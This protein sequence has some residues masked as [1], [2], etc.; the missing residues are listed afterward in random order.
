MDFE[1]VAAWHRQQYPLMQGQDW[2]K[3]CYQSEFGAGHMIADSDACLK[4]LQEEYDHTPAL[5][6]PLFEEIGSGLCRLHL[7]PLH[8]E[9]VELKWVA[10]LFQMAAQPR[11]TLTGLEAKLAQVETPAFSDYFRSYRG[12]GC[13]AVSHSEVY[14]QAYQPAYRLVPEWAKCRWPLIKA[15]DDLLQTEERVVIAI[16]GMSGSGKSTLGAHLQALFGGNLLHMD[17]FFLPFEKKTPHR[18]CQ[19]GGNVDHERFKAEVLAPLQRGEPFTFRPYQ[20]HQGRLGQPIQVTPQPLTIIEGCYS[21]HPAL[22]MPYDL[23]VFLKLDPQEQNRRILARN[24]EAL[25]KRFVKEWI[26]LENAYFKAFDVE[27]SCQVV[28]R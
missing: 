28:F 15:I 20:C 7:G 19:P 16:D 26:P 27:G 17:D 6:G 5:Q 14:R 8:L 4:R 2:A 13:P 21:L 25:H 9:Q 10:R 18:L 23:R 22:E 24:G 12:N 3:L 11:G 1:T